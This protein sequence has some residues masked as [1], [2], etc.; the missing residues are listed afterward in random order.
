[1]DTYF[2]CVYSNI[3]IP[4]ILISTT[5][6]SMMS[7][8]LNINNYIPKSGPDAALYALAIGIGLAGLLYAPFSSNDIQ[9]LT[10]RSIITITSS[11]CC[12]LT[13]YVAKKI[14]LHI[15]DLNRLGNDGLTHLTRAIQDNDIKLVKQLIEERAN[16]NVRDESGNTPLHR[17][18]NSADSQL[19]QLLLDNNASIDALNRIDETPLLLAIRLKKIDTV[20]SLLEHGG[21][22]VV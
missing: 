11:I 22:V 10:E 16:I 7:L 1:M 8:G 19:V 13:N 6:V 20:R 5:A 9:N 14:S 17:A 18:I 2:S 3:D 15:S 12:F 4:K 21:L